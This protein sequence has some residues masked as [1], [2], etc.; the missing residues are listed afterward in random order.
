MA[1]GA[2]V[3]ESVIRNLLQHGVAAGANYTAAAR[4]EG[5]HSG[6]AVVHVVRKGQVKGI[7]NGDILDQVHFINSLFGAVA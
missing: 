3:S 2:G 6:D 4:A 7:D 5:R 1:A